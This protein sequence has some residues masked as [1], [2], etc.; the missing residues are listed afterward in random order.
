MYGTIRFA[1]VGLVRFGQCPKKAICLGLVYQFLVNNACRSV[2]LDGEMLKGSPYQANVQPSASERLYLMQVA[3]HHS[4]QSSWQRAS[5][6]VWVGKSNAFL[7]V[8]CYYLYFG[9]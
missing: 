9:L 3:Q 8:L 2:K 6:N 1:E 7:K 5:C 4:E